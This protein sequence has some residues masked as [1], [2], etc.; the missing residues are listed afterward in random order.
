LARLSDRRYTA[1]RL[2][3][4]AQGES[5][6]QQISKEAHSQYNFFTRKEDVSVWVENVNGVIAAVNRQSFQ[7]Q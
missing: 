5:G 3:S 7:W 4:G 1:A 6:R 2:P